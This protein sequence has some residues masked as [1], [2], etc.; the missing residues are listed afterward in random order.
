MRAISI[1]KCITDGKLGLQNLF[2]FV[3]KNA[4]YMQAD[5]M[6]QTIFRYALKIGFSAME[7][8]FAEK[9]TGDIGPE[10]IFPFS[11]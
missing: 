7:Y 10:L 2:E 3:R 1:E 8:Y 4:E 9:E 5:E 6:E 11:G